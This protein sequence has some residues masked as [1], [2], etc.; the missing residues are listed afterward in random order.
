MDSG[1]GEDSGAGRTLGPGK[2]RGQTL[3]WG[4]TLGRGADLALTALEREG[5]LI[6]EILIANMPSLQ[7]FKTLWH[8]HGL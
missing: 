3:E 6:M 1:A 8:P 2:G 4:W 7:N 5:N